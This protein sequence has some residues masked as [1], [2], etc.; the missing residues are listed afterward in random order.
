[1]A[2]KNSRLLLLKFLAILHSPVYSGHRPATATTAIEKSYVLDVSDDWGV[3]GRFRPLA[4]SDVFK[5]FRAFSDV[6]ERFLP[7]SDVF[8]GE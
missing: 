8:F 3:F 5:P 1:M 2:S 4:F 6:F 7:F